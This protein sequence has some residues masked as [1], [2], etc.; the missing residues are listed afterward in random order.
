MRCPQKLDFLRDDFGRLVFLFF[1]NKFKTPSPFKYELTTFFFNSK[2]YL[3]I[4]IPT[5]NR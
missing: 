3:A 1:S 4:K 5:S 2:E